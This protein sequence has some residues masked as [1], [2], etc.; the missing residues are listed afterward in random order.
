[1]PGK[2]RLNIEADVSLWFPADSS[3]ARASAIAGFYRKQAVFIMELTAPSEYQD[4]CLRQLRQSW[5]WADQALK[6]TK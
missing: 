4:N 6:I 2:S 3:D 5:Y 1:M